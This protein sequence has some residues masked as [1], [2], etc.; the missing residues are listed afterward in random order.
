MKGLFAVCIVTALA[1]AVPA[2]AAPRVVASIKPLQSLAAGVMAGVAVPD[3]VIKGGGSLHTYSLRPSDAAALDKAEVV[4]WVGPAL[5]TFL[6]KPLAALA[7]KA[8]VLAMVAVPGVKLLPAQEG[9]LWEE[10]G[11]EHLHADARID[12]HLWLDSG[13]AQ[14]IVSAM[15]AALSAVD[16]VNA[17]LYRSNAAAMIAKL[18]ALDGELRAELDQIKDKAFV[19]FHDAYQYFEAAYGLRALGSVTV[20]PERTPGARRV[21]AI[22]REIARRGSS[23]IFAEPQFEPKLVRLLAG[24]TKTK[25]GMLD[26]EGSVLTSGPDLYFQLMRNLADGLVGCLSAGP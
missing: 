14:V 13:N 5:E 22:K 18:E 16:Q 17:P 4:F 11:G 1:L 6:E 26:P 10:E 7:G 24:D 2:R 3:V 9:G 19:V 25:V 8:R 12:G 21:V 15:A 20:S 23:C